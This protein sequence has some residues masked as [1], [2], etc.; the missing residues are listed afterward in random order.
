MKQQS[1]AAAR[2]GSIVMAS[3]PA[4]VFDSHDVNEAED[5]LRTAYATVRVGE[6]PEMP[7]RL[8]VKR[9]A[10]GSLRI[11]EVQLSYDMGWQT[12]PS[13][14]IRLSRVHS[15]RVHE[16]FGDGST[17]SY[18]PGDVMVVGQPDQP[19]AGRCEHAYFDVVLLRSDLLQRVAASAPG[20]TPQPVRL[21][22]RRPA[23]PAARRQLIYAFDYLTGLSSGGS[24]ALDSPLVATSA[25]D[26]L[27]AMVLTTIP[28]TACTDPTAEERRAAT[29]ALVRAAVAFIDENAHSDISLADIAAAVYITPRALQYAFRRHRDCTPTE[30]L[31]RVRLQYAHVDLLRSDPGTTVTA[32]ARRWGFAHIGRFAVLYREAYGENPRATINRS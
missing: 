30:Y 7:N 19:F 26:H 3:D 1:R 14:S 22:G 6:R 12:E 29:P 13:S 4:V 15:G 32:I 20:Y 24:A 27:A 28:N 23:S 21:T 9:G 18:G 11:D 2:W 31:R 16:H 17:S 25:A 10:L 5:F 8:R